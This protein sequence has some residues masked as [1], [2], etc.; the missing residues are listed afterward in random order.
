MTTLALCAL[1]TITAVVLAR[2]LWAVL[3][4]LHRLPPEDR[5][6]ARYDRFTPAMRRWSVL[7]GIRGRK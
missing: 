2:A 4:A 6:L 5:S 3:A 7:P 1:A